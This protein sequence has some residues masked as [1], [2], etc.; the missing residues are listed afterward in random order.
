[1]QINIKQLILE[2][3]SYDDVLMESF[4]TRK[5]VRRGLEVTNKTSPAALAVGASAPLGAAVLGGAIGNNIHGDDGTIGGVVYDEQAHN[6]DEYD[7]TGAL[8]GLAAGSLLNKK[9]LSPNYKGVQNRVKKR[10]GRKLNTLD[11]ETEATLNKT[12]NSLS[13]AQDL[14]NKLFKRS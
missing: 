7:G 10:T 6:D 12:L 11:L 4:N 1:M 13:A 2:G 8:L 3:Y 9:L 14:R 5:F